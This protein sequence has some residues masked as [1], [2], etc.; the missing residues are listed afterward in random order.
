MSKTR[1]YMNLTLEYTTDIPFDEDSSDEELQAWHV[2]QEYLIPENITF[3]DVQE[4]DVV[5]D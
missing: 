1:V 4:V 2:W 5:E 3:W